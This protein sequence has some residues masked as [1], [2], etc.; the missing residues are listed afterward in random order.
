MNRGL[1]IPDE[2]DPCCVVIFQNHW[3]KSLQ[4]TG[5]VRKVICTSHD[6]A[7]RVHSRT[8]GKSRQKQ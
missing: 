4:F 2:I 3:T 7:D 8:N 1:S 6:A 5:K